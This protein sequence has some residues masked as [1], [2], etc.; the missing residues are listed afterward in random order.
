[1]TSPDFRAHQD[2]V[3]ESIA[4]AL[5]KGGVAHAVTLSSVGT[6]K[7]DKA[8]LRTGLRGASRQLDHRHREP[9]AR[10]R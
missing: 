1:M 9:I 10:P 5:E 2:R 7:P 4:K 3:T 8:V 6:D